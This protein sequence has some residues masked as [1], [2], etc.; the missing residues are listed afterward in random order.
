MTGNARLHRRSNADTGVDSTKVIERD[1]QC[2]CGPVVLSLFAEAIRQPGE[3]ANGHAH[4]Q[5]LAL[6]MRRADS[7]GIGLPDDW[8][9]LRAHHFSR[10][11]AALALG[12]RAIDLDESRKVHAVRQRIA[13]CADVGREAFLN[14]NA[15][16]AVKDKS[17]DRQSFRPLRH[18][19]QDRKEYPVTLIAPIVAVRVLV[20]VG[21][22]ILLAD[23][24]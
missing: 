4:C 14:R 3:P 10:R 6:D 17:L 8:D 23:A 21:L 24:W 5:V 13:D 22:Q 1:V 12:S 11:I 7:C 16:H 2:E 9:Y 20:Q 15:A 18:F 19:V